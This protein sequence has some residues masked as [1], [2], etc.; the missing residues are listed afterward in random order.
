MTPALPNHDT[1]PTLSVSSA[2]RRPSVVECYQ[3]TVV[4][5]RAQRVVGVGVVLGL[6]AELLFD[7]SPLGLSLPLF[8]AAC[9][10]GLFALCGLERWQ[11][12]GRS[13]WLLAPAGFFA[14]MVAVRASD[15]L[16]AAN[17]AACA[18]LGALL[19]QLFAGERG[20]E[21]SVGGL[22]LSAAKGATLGVLAAPGALSA[23][24]DVPGLGLGARRFAGPAL[25][26]ALLTVPLLAVFTA[27]L[28]AGDDRFAELL[29]FDGAAFDW[30]NLVGSFLTV[31]GVAMAC[32]GLLTHAL[33]RRTLEAP[34]APREV[35]RPLRFTD[36]LVP[37][38][39]LAAV[40]GLFGLVRLQAVL[41]FD[42]YE[43]AA[44]L[45]FTYA[46]A[47][48]ESFGALMAVGVL[49]LVV[50][51]AFARLTR[52]ETSTQER[53]FALASLALVT[54]TVPILAC[55]LSRLVLY[56]QMYGYTELRVYASFAV[57][58]SGLLLGWR[59]V[60]LWTLKTHFGVGAGAA[61]LLALAGLDLLDPDA[62][63]A[64]RSL[65]RPKTIVELDEA[66]LMSLSADAAPVVAPYFV[67]HG[68]PEKAVEYLERV[69]RP[70]GFAGWRW[71]RARAAA[72]T[73]R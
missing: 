68:K 41:A 38:L 39:S 53:W 18:L 26:A 4:R 69:T 57:L 64:E 8:F 55:G 37:L 52:L 12:A 54:L 25:R 67:S 17:V 16:T 33:R 62:Y 40:F 22:L 49:T 34:A 63:I 27:L 47:A 50:L 30:G 70:T 14:A 5:R 32:A 43:A 10:V 45:E 72:L 19:V 42:K 23:G 2:E 51:L 56:E 1:A 13:R 31:G 20:S 15:A 46:K 24:V 61:V 36:G 29:T 48:H 7:G 71:S 65:T 44:R 6:L 3:R 58:V 59:A 66:Y 21:A 9:A 35:K 28:M 11:Q 60:T 73:R